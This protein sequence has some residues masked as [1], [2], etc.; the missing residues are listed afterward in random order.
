MPGSELDQ[1]GQRAAMMAP[2]T[3]NGHTAG[4]M[5]TRRWIWAWVLPIVAIIFLYIPG[6][7]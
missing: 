1:D 2:P 6:A 4:P 5:D 3:A 7:S